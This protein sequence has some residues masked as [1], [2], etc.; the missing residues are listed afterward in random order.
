MHDPVFAPDVRLQER[1]QI[2]LL[3]LVAEY[4][5]EDWGESFDGHE[6]VFACGPPVAI[7]SQAAAGDDV[8]YMRMKEELAGPGVEYADHTEAGADEARVLGQL[9]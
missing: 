8:M 1:E 3:Q 9:L 2:S 6:K 7:I 5:A 4:G